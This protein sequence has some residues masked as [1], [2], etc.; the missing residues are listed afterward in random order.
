[1]ACTNI[2]PTAIVDPKAELGN[3]VTVGPYS[4]IGPDVKIDNG[5]SI[6]SHVVITGHTSI[7]K[8]NQIFQFSSLGE[9]PQDKKYQG[10]P[11]KLEIGDH[12]TIR[13]FCTFNRGT[14]QDKGVTKIGNHNWIMAYVHIAHDCHVHNNTILANNSSLAGHVDMYDYAILGGFTLVHQF[15]KIGQ[16]VIT[17]VGSVVFKD[18]PPFVTASGYDAN[19]HGINAEGLKRRGFSAESITNIKRAYKTLYRQSLTLDEAK[20]KLT[21]QALTAPELSLLVEFLNES[22]RGIIR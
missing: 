20:V 17:A 16:H 3:D 2:H 9:A 5:T 18:I 21:N 4:L 22:T 7:G 10:E 6:G 15:C 12:N 14:S 19:P 13:E 1:M 11:T 8:H